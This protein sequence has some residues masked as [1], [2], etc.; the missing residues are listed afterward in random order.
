MQLVKPSFN[1]ESP[2]LPASVLQ[3]I[4][5]AGRTCYKSEDRITEDSAEKF[6]KMLIKRGHET[7]LEHEKLTIRFICD[8]GISHQIVRHRLASFSQESTHY[9]NYQTKGE[10][11]AFILPPWVAIPEGI[12]NTNNINTWIKNTWN[13]ADYSWFNGMLFAEDL[14]DRLCNNG[15]RYDKARSV[16]PMSLKTELVMTMNFRELRYFLKLRTQKT[17]HEQ[18]RELTVPLLNYLKIQYPPLFEDLPDQ[19]L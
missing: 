17:D 5:R 14:Y 6:I 19:E 8:R 12:Y 18:M 10:D 9:I 4:E 16:L 3:A 13:L 7:V 15:W 11:I 2:I 1:I